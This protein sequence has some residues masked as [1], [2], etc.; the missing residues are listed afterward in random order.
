MTPNHTF[1]DKD[2]G[3][4]SPPAP[5]P[6][7]RW[8]LG[9][10]CLFA[11]SI[12]IPLF[13]YTKIA[14]LAQSK[15]WQPLLEITNPA[16]FYGSFLNIMGSE[17]LWGALSCSTLALGIWV[18]QKL[19]RR[20]SLKDFITKAPSF[21]WKRFWVG[22]L[23]YS[24]IFIAYW[25]IIIAFT[26]LKMEPG[27]FTNPSI[28]DELQISAV[29]SKRAFWAALPLVLIFTPLNAALQEIAFRG[30]VDKGMVRI[31]P[32]KFLAFVLAGIIFAAWHIGSNGQYYGWFGFYMG[33]VIFAVCMS[34]ITDNDQGLEAAIGIHVANNILAS[35]VV[36]SPYDGFSAIYWFE[37]LETP[38]YG[39]LSMMTDIGVYGACLIILVCWSAGLTNQK[40]HD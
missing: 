5:W 11:A 20:K 10:L 38:N 35:L 15:M 33:F 19:L 31:M 12:Y 7:G 21:R 37:S 14:D 17:L 28:M 23:V 3:L 39:A 24:G 40:A 27:V 30:F 18:M 2:R 36:G 6:I 13:I 1:Y 29:P 34:C 22:G 9:I 26:A 8:I 25:L 16:H 32:N 4:A